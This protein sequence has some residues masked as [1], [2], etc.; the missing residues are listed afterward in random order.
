MIYFKSAGPNGP[1]H[2]IGTG[3]DLPD[4]AVEITEAEWF[5]LRYP[6][7]QVP[8]LDEIKTGRI[9]A[10]SADCAA[11]I[12]GGFWSSA[13]G[14]GHRYPSD[15]KDQIN[16]MGS[17][18]DSLLPDLD[19]GWQTPFWC[20]DAQGVWSWKMHTAAQ[21]QQA[22]RDGKAHVVT[23]QTTLA[24]LTIS[25]LAA[26]TSEAVSSVVWPEASEA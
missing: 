25:V 4:G 19:A 24:D 20:R 11:A 5:E 10:L 13:L 14:E 22:G 2:T 9:T 26:T 12:T 15:L 7:D 18:T 3:Y 8:S 6:L 21:I 17:V 1:A 23:C 16:L